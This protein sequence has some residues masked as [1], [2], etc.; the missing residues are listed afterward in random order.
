MECKGRNGITESYC[1]PIRVL[2]RL[3]NVRSSSIIWWLWFEI[4]FSPYCA[5]AVTKMTEV[6]QLTPWFP[7]FV[8]LTSRKS[9]QWAEQRASSVGAWPEPATGRRF[10]VQNRF[11]G[12]AVK[13][14]LGHVPLVTSPCSV[15]DCITW[16]TRGLCNFM[17]DIL[18]EVRTVECGPGI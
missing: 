7:L 15:I 18:N 16:L 3:E 14:W 5:G 8:G 1:S 9:G 6:R 4:R 10:S 11:P 13:A 12:H 17:R 2:A